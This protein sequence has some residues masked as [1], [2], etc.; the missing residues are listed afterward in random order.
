MDVRLKEAEKLG[1]TQAIIPK[2]KLSTNRNELNATKDL[3]QPQSML[4][5]TEVTHLS[6]LV[7]NIVAHSSSKENQ[8]K[9][10]N[11]PL[12]EETVN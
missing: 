6:D 7:A 8:Y 5:I 10:R 4:T 1:F 11:F 2:A 12:E 9:T 3:L